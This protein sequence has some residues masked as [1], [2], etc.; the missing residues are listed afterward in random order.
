MWKGL[1][2]DYHTYLF[3]PQGAGTNPQCLIGEHGLGGSRGINYA[4][5]FRA[6]IPILFRSRQ[7]GH[8]RL[9]SPFVTG[10]GGVVGGYPQLI[11]LVAY[12]WEKK[13]VISTGFKNI[14]FVPTT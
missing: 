3:P 5:Q 2:L 12:M 8:N 4:G 6:L 7:L 1:G 13:R 9:P 10:D 11:L 14:T